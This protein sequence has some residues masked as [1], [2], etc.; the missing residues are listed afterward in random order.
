MSG[1]GILCFYGVGMG[2]LEGEQS[3]IQDFN[4]Y[5]TS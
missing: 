3:R 1:S 5:V 2:D 4:S